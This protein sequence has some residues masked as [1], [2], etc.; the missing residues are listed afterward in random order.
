MILSRKW[1][2]NPKW[3]KVFVNNSSD[4]EFVPMI[5]KEHISEQPMDQRRNKK[6]NKNILRQMKMEIEHTQ[7]YKMQ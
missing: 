5:Y 2:D 3:E 6:G 1:K 7:T 4:K